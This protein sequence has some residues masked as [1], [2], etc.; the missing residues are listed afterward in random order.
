VQVIEPNVMRAVNSHA[1]ATLDGWTPPIDCLG[2]KGRN[3]KRL[4][5]EVQG[6]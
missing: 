5:A 4:P 6:L 1:N 2:L 3:I